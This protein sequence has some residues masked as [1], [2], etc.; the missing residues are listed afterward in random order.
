[1]ENKTYVKKIKKIICFL[2][3]LQIYIIIMVKHLTRACKPKGKGKKMQTRKRVA[4]KKHHK[5][6]GKSKTYRKR[7]GFF[8]S[9]KTNNASTNNTNN[10]KPNPARELKDEILKNLDNFPMAKQRMKLKLQVKGE[11]LIG[12]NED[13]VTQPKSVAY[14]EIDELLKALG[15]NKAADLFTNLSALEAQYEAEAAEAARR[16]EIGASGRALENGKAAASAAYEKGKDTAKALAAKAK[17]ASNKMGARLGSMFGRKNTN[18]KPN[19][20]A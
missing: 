9:K 16:N 18:N 8:G 1:V 19:N 2:F 6:H 12:K 4:T 11:Q 14:R 20:K 7:G 10:G 13:L 3:F 5:K 15:Y 17:N